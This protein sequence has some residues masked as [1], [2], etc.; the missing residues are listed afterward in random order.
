MVMAILLEG[1]MAVIACALGWAFGPYPW[2]QLRW[3]PLSL[4]WTIVITLPMIALFFG[5]VL[6]PVRPLGPIKRFVDQVVKPLFQ[7]CS[8]ADMALIAILAGLG[9]ELLFR[10]ILQR[11]LMDWL[12][13]SPWIGL[14]LA[15]ILF[16]LFHPITPGYILLASLL[17]LYLGWWAWQLNN[18]T[19]VVIAH[20]VYDFVALVYVV[21]IEKT[22]EGTEMTETT[23]KEE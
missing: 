4:V 9:E 6:M 7:Q 12:P 16:G 23:K 20:A 13:Y 3:D 21:R 15:S 18:L 14:V 19:E 8:L 11:W 5:C 17:G 10:G 1:G 2:E 22:T